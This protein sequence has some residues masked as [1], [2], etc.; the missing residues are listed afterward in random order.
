MQQQELNGHTPP[1]AV[2][3]ALT[4]PIADAAEE[5]HV[6]VDE[7]DTDEQVRKEF[8]PDK[9][10]ELEASFQQHGQLNAIII[11]FDPA[12][13]RYRNIAGERRLRAARA[14]GWK[15]IRARV[16]KERPAG[17]KL[18]ELQLVENDQRHDLSEMERGKAFIDYMTRTGC[19][20][21]ALAQKLGKPVNAITRPIN[22]FKRL[23]EDVRALVGKEIP[24]S[25]AEVLTS[26]PN[27]DAKR[28][29]AA[30]YR[31]KK[32]Q[33]GSELAAAIKAAR[34]GQAADVTSGFTCQDQ[35][36]GVKISVT[37][38]GQDLSR[39][40]AVVRQLGKDLSANGHRG[41]DKFKDFLTRKARAAKKAAELKAAQE[42]LAGLTNP[43]PERSTPN[44]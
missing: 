12:T 17:D 37:F 9:A 35:E 27:D 11:Y 5:R 26:L 6:P 20:A 36:S 39:V 40:E 42:A 21:S 16:L 22:L 15:T 10:R 31:E 19:T 28:H 13:R 44:A 7:I 1:Q 38:P 32:V 33:S 2:P 8:D 18:L 3:A 24:S 43:T 34:N 23:P 41:L 30:L 25:V 4:A 29:W 14:L